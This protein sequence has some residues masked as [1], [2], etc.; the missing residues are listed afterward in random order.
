[1][2]KDAREHFVVSLPYSLAMHTSRTWTC[3]LTLGK[4]L[5]VVR[6]VSV[7]RPPSCRSSLMTRANEL[8]ILEKQQ[9]RDKKSD[10]DVNV[11][12]W[13]LQDEE[14]ASLQSIESLF[15]HITSAASKLEL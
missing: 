1:V 5:R 15:L 14:E 12:S 7:L 4:F 10:V 11:S 2:S 6:V 9:G 13:R 8:G 3:S